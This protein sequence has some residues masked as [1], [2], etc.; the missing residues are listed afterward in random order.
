MEEEDTV[1]QFEL[2]CL[3]TLL[4]AHWQTSTKINTPAL[5]LTNELMR[6]FVLEAIQRATIEAQKGAEK[7]EEQD[8]VK[9][10]PH[11]ILAIL[12]GLLLDFS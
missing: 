4:Q 5:K 11:H 8:A 7:L 2:G 1:P 3:E 6:L 12:P 10:E 9:L